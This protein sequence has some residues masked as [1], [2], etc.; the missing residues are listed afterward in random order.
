M[1]VV[2]EYTRHLSIEGVLKTVEVLFVKKKRDV[3]MLTLLI[4]VFGG[5]APVSPLL[6]IKTAIIFRS[7]RFTAFQ[8]D[9][10]LI[11]FLWI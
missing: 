11:V 7:I 4:L 6:L 9:L 2:D 10:N 8:S 3:D 5:L 1:A